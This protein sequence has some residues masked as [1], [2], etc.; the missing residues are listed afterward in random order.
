MNNASTRLPL[1]SPYYDIV[2]TYIA[3]F[4]MDIHTI[5]A[6]KANEQCTFS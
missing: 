3:F 6:F 2:I 1:F 4:D 5:F